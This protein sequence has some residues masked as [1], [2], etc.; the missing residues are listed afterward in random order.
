MKVKTVIEMDYS[1]LED[2]VNKHYKLKGESK[3]SFVATAECG[4]DSDHSF[5]VPRTKPLDKWAQKNIQELKEG[6]YP[7]YCNHDILQD[8]VNNGVLAPGEYLIR[9]SW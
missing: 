7:S 4:N 9:V 6:R 2:I 8:L 1:E 5:N 3:Y